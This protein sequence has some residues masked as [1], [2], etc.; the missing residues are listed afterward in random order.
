MFLLNGKHLPEGVSFYDANGTQYPSGWLNQSTEEQKAAIGITWVAD[1]TPFD[2]RFYWD[3]NLPKALEDKLEVKEDGSPLYKQ[4]YD[5]DADNGKGAM[6]DTTEQVITKGLKSNFISQ[7]KQTAGSLLQTTDWTIIR[8]AERGIDVPA[9]IA[10][11]RAHIISEANRLE[12]AITATT[13]VEDLIA[14]LN[15]QNWG[16]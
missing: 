3:H 10:D 9:T 2:P 11:K 13:T 16:E 7:I 1:P 6:V 5:K 8:K 15:N 14:V 12:T 4:V